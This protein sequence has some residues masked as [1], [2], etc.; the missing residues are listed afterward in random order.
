MRDLLDLLEN[1]LLA[2]KSRGLLYREKGDTFFQGDKETPTA[3]ITFDHVDYF[4]GQPG[5]YE[6]FEET[7]EAYK[8]AE[9][10]YPGINWT[11]K[12]TRSSKSF[13]VLTFDGP[14]PN[15]KTYFGRFFGEIKQDMSGAWGNNGLP[16][17]WQLNKAA[18]LK[19]S[20][21][22]LKPT[23]LFP[24]DSSY[25]SPK[26]CVAALA[27][28][29][30]DNPAV[31]KIMPGMEE[32]LRGKFP[33]FKNAGEMIPA[34]RDDLGETIGPIALIQ[35]MITS[36]GAEAARKDILGPN[37]SY[38]GSSIYFPGSK[39]NGLVDSYITTP[40][41]IEI[42]ISSKGEKGATASAKN[43]ADGVN[44]AREKEMTDLLEKYSE[45]IKVIEEVANLTSREFPIKLGIE[46][47]IITARQGQLINQLID[48]S[49]TSLSDVPMN[50]ADRQV[51]A[52]LMADVKPK[53][54]PR[55]N[56]GYHI[57]SS[58]A[59]RVVNAINKDPVFGEACL[60]F[61]NVSPIIQLHLNG[62]VSGS[63]LQVTGFSSK[64]PPDFRGEVG[65][66]ASKVYAATG[67]G[68][69]V[70]FAYNPIGD[71]LPDAD[72]TDS[73]PAQSAAVSTAELDAVSQ[74]RSKVKARREPEGDAKSLGRKRR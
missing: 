10:Q 43:I 71:G 52:E 54:N 68:G 55:Y 24:P 56:T 13:A 70:T 47:E 39:I 7:I 12:P 29:P 53:P 45:Q 31:P 16:G 37:G 23:D 6:T 35:G 2:E 5:A 51:L 60:K 15:Q 38:S 58:L 59:R 64:Y 36:Q 61:L 9:K 48:M 44:R 41:G 25:A 14:Q 40:G 4:P 1:I 46:K 18:S 28:N 62:S 49:A 50:E 67:T 33:V 65:L 42:G 57:L 19:G 22:K 72:E 21:Y 34:I 17:N 32:L 66:D 74:K 30:K 11:N 69:R 26:A 73:V 8:Q 3:V 27:S 63:D 20:Y